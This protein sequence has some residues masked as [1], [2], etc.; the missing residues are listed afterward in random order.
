MQ[1]KNVEILGEE[2]A[3][4]PMCYVYVMYCRYWYTLFLGW[5]MSF[6]SGIPDVCRSEMC[7]SSFFMGTFFFN[8]SLLS[9]NARGTTGTFRFY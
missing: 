7:L 9:G 2:H 4:Y 5:R 8:Q 6:V 3:F 1:R